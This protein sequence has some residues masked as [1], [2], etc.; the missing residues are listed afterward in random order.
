M[1]PSRFAAAI[2]ALACAF[3]VPVRI[4]ASTPAWWT[5]PAT[6][7]VDPGIEPAPLAPA[8][9]GQLKHVALQA[10]LH[11]DE[12]L[13]PVDGAGPEIRGLVA[14]FG[15]DPGLNRSLAQI[16]HLKAVAD[17]FYRRLV[18]VGYDT[19]ANL[20][21]R[22]YPADDPA[23]PGVDEA[24]PHHVPWDPADPTRASLA[25]LTQGQLKMVFSF[26]LEGFDLAE[27]TLTDL[28]GDGASDWSET[29]LLGTNPATFDSDGD[30]LPDGWE[31]LRG[32]D[33][34]SG[35]STTVTLEIFHP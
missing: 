12:H 24:W 35:G 9:L 8:T 15:R 28:D 22:G 4:D 26:D 19:R 7:I 1:R 27:P 31:A 33:P 17:R 18:V 34:A 10:G 5:D 25:P 11:L 6:A 21:A 3:A 20:I 29:H 13:G 16:G 14:S 23:T 2:V 30:G 32:F